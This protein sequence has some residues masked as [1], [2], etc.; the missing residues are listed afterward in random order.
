L[1]DASEQSLK[2]MQALGIGWTVQDAM[3]FGG[4]QFRQ[5]SGVEA[6]TLT[7]EVPL[8]FII[9]NSRFKRAEKENDPS[10]MRVAADIYTVG[11]GFFSTMGISILA[12]GWYING[13]RLA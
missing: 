3:Y 10:A 6:A 4:D 8:T 9:N 12:G 13:N 1:N 5:T 11:P 7:T 2:R